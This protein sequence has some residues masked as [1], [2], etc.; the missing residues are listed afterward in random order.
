MLKAKQEEFAGFTP[1]EVREIRGA[2][3]KLMVIKKDRRRL[4]E[5]EDAAAEDLAAT[6]RRHKQY[7]WRTGKYL[8][9]LDVKDRIT[10]KK[11]GGENGQGGD[12]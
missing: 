10:I 11:Q 12:R 7:A 6:M 2:A 4:K 3:E 9:T 8:I 1:Q 5:Q